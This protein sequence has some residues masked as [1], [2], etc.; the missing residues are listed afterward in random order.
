MLSHSGNNYIATKGS[1]I[2]LINYL[3]MIWIDKPI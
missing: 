3:S 2:I 1:Q